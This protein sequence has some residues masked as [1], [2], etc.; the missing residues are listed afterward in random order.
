M[1]QSLCSPC[2]AWYLLD[3]Y[4]LFSY[5]KHRYPSLLPPSFLPLPVP[6]NLSARWIVGSMFLSNFIGIV[7]ARSLHFQ[8]YVWYFHSLPFLLWATSLDTRIRLLV[9]F[10]IER[11]WN[12]FP[13]TPESSLT[14]QAMHLLILGALFVSPTLNAD[15][16]TSKTRSAA[17]VAEGSSNQDKGKK[18][19]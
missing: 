1:T 7:C 13:S 3:I 10:L 17:A 16:I 18:R 9:L 15:T 2:F 8:F 5:P 6:Q 12:V 4:D 19:D 11:V 14:L